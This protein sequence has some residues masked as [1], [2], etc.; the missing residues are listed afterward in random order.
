MKAAIIAIL[1]FTSLTLSAPSSLETRQSAL[2]KATD[3]YAFSITLEQFIDNR[4]K[5]AGP[6]GLD[7]NSNGCSYS[8]DNPFGFDC[9][10]LSFSHYTSARLTNSTSQRLLSPSRLRLPQLQSTAPLLKL[11]QSSH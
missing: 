7:W 11:Y 9:T 5:K 2:Q 4:N 1:G 10:V 8:P 6:T 3:K